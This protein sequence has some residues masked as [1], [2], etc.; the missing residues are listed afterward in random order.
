M[1]HRG[2]LNVLAN[3]LAKGFRVIFHEFSGGTANPED[4]GGSDDVKYHL[5]TSTDRSFDGI[6]VHMSLVPN[7]SHLET[8]DPV[9]PAQ[10]LAQQVIRDDLP[11]HQEVHPALIHADASF[12]GQATLRE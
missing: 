7:P 9:V 5:G 4:V 10:V 11:Q 3:V 2:R 8:V 1:A 6:N 12:P